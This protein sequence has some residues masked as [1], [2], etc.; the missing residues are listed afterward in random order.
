MDVL[1]TRLIY[2][3]LTGMVLTSLFAHTQVFA[4]GTE[5][6]TTVTNTATVSYTVG[7]VTQSVDSDGDTGTAGNQTTDF[8]VDSKIDHSLTVTAVNQGV[9][10]GQDLTDPANP[11]PNP[12]VLHEFTL[13]N[14]GNVDT[15]YTLDVANPATGDFTVGDY[16]IYIDNGDN[17]FDPAT[18][19]L[20]GDNAAV[21]L[22]TALAHDSGSN[23]LTVFVATTVLSTQGPGD[24]SNLAL[25][26]TATDAGGSILVESGGPNTIGG[27][28]EIVFADGNG[29][30]AN[31]TD[32]DFDAIYALDF[33]VTVNASLL[34]VTKDVIVLN[35]GLGSEDTTDD[36]EDTNALMIPGATIRYIFSINNPTANEATAV[37]FTD[38]LPAEV[39]YEDDGA[40]SFGFTDCDSSDTP[41]LTYDS[42]DNEIEVDDV[43]IAAGDTCVVTFDVV[44]Q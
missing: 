24:V 11:S 3:L 40:N 37:G 12:P 36:T 35:D 16:V 13:T 31:T 44:I 7:G 22:T 1:N 25:I 29:S 23:Q 20:V 34:T 30:P 8:T 21:T 9:D 17:T 38:A 2:K 39:L 28:A 14:E 32:V 15:F 43:T 41:S 18:D 10:A 27:A 5:S 42:G 33:T 4:I 6:G 19:T 26:V